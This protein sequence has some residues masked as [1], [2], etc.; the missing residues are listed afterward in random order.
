[1]TIWEKISN[2]KPS[3]AITLFCGVM[4]YEDDISK[5]VQSCIDQKFKLWEIHVKPDELES[6]T[7]IRNFNKFYY[8]SFV[9]SIFPDS[10]NSGKQ[11][12]NSDFADKTIRYTRSLDQRVPVTFTTKDAVITYDIRFEYLDLYFFPHGIVVYCFKCD[13]SDHTFDEIRFINGQLRNSGTIPDMKF[14]YDNLSLLE[15][16]DQKEKGS[17]SFGNK[18]KL[19]TLIEHNLEIS[20]DD[21]NML[22]YDIGTCAPIGTAA[23]EAPFLEPSPEYYMELVDRNRISVFNN[24]TALC[25]F[26]TFTGLFN[27]KALNDFVWEN[28]YFNLLYVAFENILTYLIALT[29]CKTLSF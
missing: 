15:T 23:G 7:I 28:G 12:Y 26:D 2:S 18:L 10:D 3:R 8:E 24:W 13:L 4:D 25:L 19:F 6:K 17:M 16:K 21:E 5:K 29:L 27:K 20:K 1:M 9:N 11:Y 14:L 22:L